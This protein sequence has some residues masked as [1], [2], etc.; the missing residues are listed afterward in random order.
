MVVSTQAFG[1]YPGAYSR[2]HSSAAGL[3]HNVVCEDS[4]FENSRW[5]AGSGVFLV[6]ASIEALSDDPASP[7]HGKNARKRGPLKERPRKII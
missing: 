4:R 1:L 7:L 6:E 5:P 3:W 2:P